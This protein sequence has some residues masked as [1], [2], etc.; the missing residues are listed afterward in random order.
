M[1]RTQI[2]AT[3]LCAVL[4]F[5]LSACQQTTQTAPTDNQVNEFTAPADD[6]DEPTTRAAGTGLGTIY[7]DFDS[8]GIRS[9]ARTVLK[10]NAEALRSSGASITVEGHC[11]ERGDEEYNLALGERR[12]NSVK[13]YLVDLGVDG[14][15][16]GTIS[17]GESKPAAV[18]R[19]E[20]A[21]QWNRRAEFTAR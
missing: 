7:F 10:K 20:S 18:G 2:L 16:V 6:V 11:D 12:A 4:V 9:D 21:W 14:G 3:A 15:N 1:K 13:S 8:A 17:Y 5:G 19:D